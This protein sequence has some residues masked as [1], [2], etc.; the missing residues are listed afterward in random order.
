MIIYLFLYIW[1]ILCVQCFNERTVRLLSN[2]IAMC[3][4]VFPYIAV[5][6][7]LVSWPD[8]TLG[9]LCTPCLS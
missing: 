5:W 3:F 4:S 2:Q 8:Y 7:H 9:C 1:F 6:S